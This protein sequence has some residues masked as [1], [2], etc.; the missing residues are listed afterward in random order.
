MINLLYIYS[1]YIH[2]KTYKLNFARNWFLKYNLI[3]VAAFGSIKHNIYVLTLLKSILGKSRLYYN[4]ALFNTWH[5][6][7]LF[8][9]LLNFDL[10][11]KIINFFIYKKNYTSDAII[12]VS[13]SASYEL[14][15]QINCI[16]NVSLNYWRVSNSDFLW[17]QYM[18]Y[19]GILKT[20]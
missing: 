20:F 18:V 14:T 5:N 13:L 8:W 10:F 19:H 7:Y 9:H 11:S 15:Q 6:F 4:L 1:L 16:S 2:D 17:L 3:I 12:F